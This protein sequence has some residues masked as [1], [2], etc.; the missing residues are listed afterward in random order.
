[1]MDATQARGR[2]FVCDANTLG[3]A[4]SHGD[5]TVSKRNVSAS[6]RHIVDELIEER[7]ERIIRHPLWP[8][9]KPALY[10]ILHY[11]RAMT[12]ADD[13]VGRS[14]IGVLDYL[15]DLLALDV[16][17]V[18]PEHIPADGA[19]ILASNHPTGIA[20]GI[21]VYEALRPVRQDITVFT[22]RDA[23]RVNPNLSEVL[24]PVEWRDQ[25]RSPSKTKETLRQSARAFQ[26]GRAIVIFPSGRIA[27]WAGGLRERPWQA[28]AVALARKNQVPIL[29]VHIDARNSGLFYFFATWNTELRDMTVFHELLNKRGKTFRLTFGRPI[30]PDRL[31]GDV[32]ERTR[33]LQAFCEGRLKDDSTATFEG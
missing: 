21:A 29:P 23:I 19:F 27:Y 18:M 30:E 24:I 14:G 22:N 25:F 6:G 32:G 3:D 8:L 28:S 1:M 7:G 13:I 15:A 5:P 17:T 31:E 11:G 12:M 4:R 9:L 26:D 2:G 10:R 33:K 16:Q 20:D